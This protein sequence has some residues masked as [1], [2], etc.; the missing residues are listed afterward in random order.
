VATDF[1]AQVIEQFRASDGRP[2]GPFEGMPMLLLHH[3]GRQTGTERVNPL[4]YLAVDGGWAVF[5]S[6][7]GG[8]RNPEWYGNLL[9]Q[10]ETAIEIGSEAVR[11]RAREASGAERDEIF[12]R[13]KAVLPAFAEYEVKAGDRVIPVIVLEPLA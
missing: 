11:V 8:P 6:Y 9:A 10:P 7:A 13:Q 12:E 1:N 5:A 3:R 2:G 4:A